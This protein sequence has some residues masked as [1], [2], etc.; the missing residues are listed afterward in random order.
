MAREL[1]LTDQNRIIVF[2][3][4]SGTRLEVYYRTVTS[5][6][7]IKYKSEILNLLTKSHDIE[8]TINLQLI[9]AEKIITGFKKGDFTLEGKPISSDSTDSAYYQGWLA[10]LRETATD[11]LLSIVETLLGEPSFVVRDNPLPFEKS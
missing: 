7:R 8:E 6:D 5:T 11:I 2:D 4:L 1:K 9:W 3:K 10:V